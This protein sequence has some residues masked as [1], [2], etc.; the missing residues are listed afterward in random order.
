MKWKL[1]RKKTP[2]ESVETTPANDDV[3]DVTEEAEEAKEPEASPA[4]QA[5]DIQELLARITETE[6]PSPT[7]RKLLQKAFDKASRTV[8]AD[9]EVATD[10]TLD[11][12]NNS[13]PVLEDEELRGD[14]IARLGWIAAKYPQI[15]EKAMVNLAEARND[16]N[17]EIRESALN[18]ITAVGMSNPDM[19]AKA[20]ALLSEGLDN[21]QPDVRIKAI[22]GLNSLTMKNEELAG[23]TVA[24]FG[25][26]LA[27]KP[28]TE[29]DGT[30]QPY[31]GRIA[32]ARKLGE[33]GIAFPA[34]K[35]A[36]VAALIPGLDDEEIFTK[37]RTIESL[38]QVGKAY[39]DTIDTIVDAM[40]KA[41]EGQIYIVQQKLAGAMHT[42]KPPPEPVKTPEEL[43]AERKAE[44]ASAKAA[45]EAAKRVKEE[46][47]KKA[48][49][50][51]QKKDRF[52]S[53][54]TLAN[55]L[56]GAKL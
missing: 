20:H 9:P 16:A 46:Q 24:A 32:A 30:I 49:A 42:L 45:E 28:D 53:I 27:K 52:E 51:K 10:E 25:K 21:R 23:D 2:S 55:K 31:Q 39:E 18:G 19:M 47:E 5:A 7:E 22:G 6:K 15:A 26:V 3:T 44:E 43:E 12:F 37:Y 35:D 36:V 48:A 17:A 1:F 11:A 29:E 4:E 8:L 56:P 33:L 34:Q 54:K 41:K 50:E 40:D 38:I 13:A 14:A